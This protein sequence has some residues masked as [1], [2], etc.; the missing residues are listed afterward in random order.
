[1]Y[2]PSAAQPTPGAGRGFSVAVIAVLGV[3]A[4]M[5]LAG[6]V[7]LVL[8]LRSAAGRLS[9]AANPPLPAVSLPVTTPGS[10]LVLP[11]IHGVTLSHV[12]AALQAQGYTCTDTRQIAG[13][14][15]TSC[16]LT[17][18]SGDLFQVSLGGSDST[19]V[20]L[21]SA[22]LVSDL[23]APPS[24]AEA[25]RFFVLVVGA[26]TQ[27][28]QSAQVNSWVQQHLDSGGETTSGN[29][30]LQLGRPGSNYLLLVTSASP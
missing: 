5:L 7:G 11:P 6:G 20:G 14:W 9:S 15:V 16:S 4:V 23:R 19:S 17:D 21:I 8:A 2:Q 26:V 1:M 13:A 3:F 12:T 27:G 25:S 18:K 22:G 10:S 28:S 30:H 29:L 24:S